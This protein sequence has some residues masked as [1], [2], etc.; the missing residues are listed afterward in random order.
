[1][2]CFKKIFLYSACL[3]LFGWGAAALAQPDIGLGKGGLANQI[4]RESGYNPSGVT[5]T[6][7]SASIGKVI[8][9]ALSMV[10][11][12][13]LA[14]TVYA[15]I[16]WMT[17]SGNEEKVET[18]IKILRSAAVGLVILLAA[19]GITALV[20]AGVSFAAQPQAA[21]NQ[22]QPTYGDFLKNHFQRMFFLQ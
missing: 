17:A 7:L 13:F 18:A 10:G 6:T 21:L 4:G 12:L 19:Y 20:L 3:A 16:L 22:P 2:K 11:V 1:M 8:R 5:D 9:V 15:G 14:L